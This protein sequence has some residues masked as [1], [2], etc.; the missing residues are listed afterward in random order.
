MLKLPVNDSEHF[1]RFLAEEFQHDGES[2]VVAPG[3]G[4]YANP[5][6][7]RDQ[8]RLAAVLEVSKL[9]RASQLIGIALQQ[10]D[11]RP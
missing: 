6:L 2:V 8:V 11:N 10:Y 1:A 5:M 9:Q 4:F 3:P 7:G